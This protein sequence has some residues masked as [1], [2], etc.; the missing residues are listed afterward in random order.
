MGGSSQNQTLYLSR[1]GRMSPSLRLWTRIVLEG[2][3]IFSPFSECRKIFNQQ[4]QLV[5]GKHTKTS[6]DIS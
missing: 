2:A 5:T 3:Q 4:L 6:Q 1:V